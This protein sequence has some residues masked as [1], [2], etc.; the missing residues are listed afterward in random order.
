MDEVI[1][2]LLDAIPESLRNVSG[3]AMSS[4]LNSWTNP[5]PVYLLGYNPGGDPGEDTVYGNALDL[6]HNCKPDHSPYVDESW[7]VRGHQYGAGE[8]PMQVR[9]RYLLDS[10]GLD[11]GSVPT[12]NIIYARSAVAADLDKRQA[13][14]WANLCW[15]FHARMIDQLR[16]RV[17][18]CYGGQ[19][20]AFVRTKLFAHT[21]VETYR[22][23]S[24]RRWSSHVHTG[25][26]A[27]VVQLAHPG[28]SKW[29]SAD[30][31]PT[32]LVLRA[33]AAASAKHV[34]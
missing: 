25:P 20:A 22:E 23:Q 10:L 8:A 9:V 13:L 33:L 26:G 21:H 4:G 27:T 11:P 1:A 12:S 3:S 32:G 30:A 5:S 18:V 17:V 15:P 7:L 24:G 16:V 34:Q 31:D 29:T 19:A 6:I 2:G 14:E 28:R